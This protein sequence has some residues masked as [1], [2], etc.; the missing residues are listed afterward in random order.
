VQDA[1]QNRNHL[2]VIPAKAGIHSS[3]RGPGF[4]P[5]REWHWGHMCPLASCR[6]TQSRRR[7]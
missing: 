5:S 2:D 6:R 4:P 7:P 1:P 3:V